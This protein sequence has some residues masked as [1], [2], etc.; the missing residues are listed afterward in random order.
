MN[1]YYN[2]FSSIGGEQSNCK[3]LTFN[4][5]MCLF[6]KKVKKFFPSSLL[7]IVQASLPSALAS[8]S[9]K[10]IFSSSLLGI[11]Q[12]SLP[13]ALASSSVDDFHWRGCLFGR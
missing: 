8:S 12:A 7:G 1:F 5:A 9:V 10:K 2:F 6:L 3:H 13:S 4:I 11:V